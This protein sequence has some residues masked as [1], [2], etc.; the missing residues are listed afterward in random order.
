MRC[1]GTRCSI[2]CRCGWAPLCRRGPRPSRTCPRCL[3]RGRPDRRTGRLGGGPLA[4][5]V[6]V[7]VHPRRGQEAVLPGGE[8]AAAK[9]LLQ[10]L[11]LRLYAGEKVDW[12]LVADTL[13]YLGEIYYSEGNQDQAEVL[14]RYLL[15][16]D[17][18]TPISAFHHSVEVVNLFELVRST[19]LKARLLPP[20]PPQVVQPPPTPVWVFLPLGVA[21]FAQHRPA[22]GFV[23]GTLEAGFA[24]ASIVFRT[25][26]VR[27]NSADIT[28]PRAWDPAKVERVEYLFQWPATFG[29]YL[30]WGISTMD[31]IRRAPTPPANAPGVDQPQRDTDHRDLRPALIRGR[32]ALPV[33]H[34]S[35]A[36][37]SCRRSEGWMAFFRCDHT[38]RKTRKDFSI[39]K[40]LTS[41]GRASGNDLVL[42]DPMI[43]PTHANLMRQG[44]TFTLTLLDK[45]ELY[46]N[47]R[48]QRTALLQEGDKV[49]LGGWQLTWSE[50]EPLQEVPPMGTGCRSIS[51]QSLV[52][53][54][55]EMM[56]DTAPEKLFA[57]MLER[58]VALTGAEKGFVIVMQDGERHLAART[59]S[60]TRPSTSPRSATRS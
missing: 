55:S 25:Q 2:S 59:T 27:S 44:T 24:S 41:I 49:L 36:M 1:P 31:G 18:N 32:S 43:Q 16:Q 21:Q 9:E 23:Y 53:L 29:F 14:F 38:I 11:Q 58:L 51:L 48:R 39:R 8:A 35:S 15:E 60:R 13:I 3:V 50:G 46:V 30:T 22:A 4:R 20:P 56:R 40:V 12:A 57:T 17:P 37:P 7:R 54:S 26:L 47:G 33:R 28:N 5:P 52:E 34:C 6:L 10:G 19:I 42:D 45:G